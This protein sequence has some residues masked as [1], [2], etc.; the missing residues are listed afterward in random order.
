M[1]PAKRQP[2]GLLG[3][4][5]GSGLPSG[6][7]Q[8]EFLEF[9]VTATF[10]RILVYGDFNES[11]G[12]H[13]KAKSNQDGN[14][15]YVFAIG[16]NILDTVHFNG[17]RLQSN[18]KELWAAM[19]DVESYWQTFSI[20]H[21]TQARYNEI[22][23]NFKNDKRLGANGVY[24]AN[25]LKNLSISNPVVR[26]GFGA[27]YRWRQGNFGEFYFKGKYFEITVSQET[28]IVLQL[29]PAVDKKGVPCM[30]D[31][32]SKQPFY[33]L[34]P[35]SFIVGMDMKQARKLGK[36][37]AG[38]GELTVSLPSNYQEDEGVVNALSK[39]QENDWVITIQTY[40]AEAAASTFALRRVWVRKRAEENG[41]YVDTDGFRW[42]V[43]WCVDVVGSSPEAEGYEPF[44][45]VESA[46]E[47]W[48][49]QPWV[50]PES[51]I[52]NDENE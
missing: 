18:A 8:A 5:S 34:G 29:I 4:G 27:Q 45:S 23:Y 11:T 50:D 12:L 13:I 26:Y 20:S 38:G 44:R 36:L 49:L 1:A 10:Q 51:E 25:R 19:S 30:F 22:F 42:Q 48:G 17:L 15:A 35:G 31:K 9:G 6:Y 52:T 21:P 46:T 41:S 28:E 14:N 2:F 16:D 43:E 7:L 37:P 47:Y 3:R 32:V 33:N 39:A 24:S 40:A